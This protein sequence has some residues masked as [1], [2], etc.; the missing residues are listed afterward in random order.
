MDTA[1]VPAKGPDTVDKAKVSIANDVFCGAFAASDRHRLPARF[2]HIA[3]SQSAHYI[4]CSCQSAM[5]LHPSRRPPLNTEA[6]F[7]NKVLDGF[8]EYRKNFLILLLAISA[9]CQFTTPSKVF[10]FFHSITRTE[11]SA[12]PY[13]TYSKQDICT[14]NEEIIATLRKLFQVLVDHLQRAVEDGIKDAKKKAKDNFACLL[15][16]QSE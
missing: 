5:R 7:A 9:N 15:V 3:G 12:I 14:V 13:R 4:G 6:Q 1:N 16:L 11:S 10:P 8:T 2:F